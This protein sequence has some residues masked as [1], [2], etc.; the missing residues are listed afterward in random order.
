M[1]LGRLLVEG[2]DRLLL[3]SCLLS[4]IPRIQLIL[5]WLVCLVDA[6]DGNGDTK[7]CNCGREAV[8][9]IVAKAD[10]AHK[11]RSFWT[12]PQPQGEQCGFF[13]SLLLL[14]HNRR[15]LT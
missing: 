11:G 12:C 14:H 8:S 3:V 13:V 1:E 7:M 5:N 9:R 2:H 4:P 15:V 6:D 10:S